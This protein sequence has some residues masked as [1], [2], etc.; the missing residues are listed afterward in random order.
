MLCPHCNSTNLKKDG[1]SNGRQMY[2]CRD[3]L[4]KHTEGAKVHL[5]R[6]IDKKLRKVRRP[7]HP[8]EYCGETTTRPRFCSNSCAS[9]Y[10]NL[11]H[12]KR[13]EKRRANRIIKT[14][15]YCGVQLDGRRT[16]CLTCNHNVVEW[17]EVL[18]SEIEGKA[19]YQIHAQVRRIARQTYR[20]SNRPKYCI[21]CGY[22]TH[23]EVCH[24]RP[25]TDFP[26]ETKVGTINDLSNLVALCPNCH[27]EFDNDYL[28]IEE[29]RSK[30]NAIL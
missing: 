1:I 13:Y 5:L 2:T 4:H 3:C 26:L 23:Y 12:P 29:I 10:S 6:P 18:L 21:N 14:C 16:T 28:T 11:N 27:W 20:N 22:N 15:K 19:K 8:C 24:I 30:N 9:T 7:A 17:D 25:I